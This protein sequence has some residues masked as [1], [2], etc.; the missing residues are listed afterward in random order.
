MRRSIDC[1][2]PAAT[3]NVLELV[4]AYEL[5]DDPEDS[6]STILILVENISDKLLK[7]VDIDTVRF[8]DRADSLLEEDW[9]PYVNGRLI[10][11][12]TSFSSTHIP[13]GDTG[14]FELIGPAD[15]GTTA[16]AQIDTI[17]YHEETN[18]P[19][20]SSWVKLVDYTWHSNNRLEITV[21]NHVSQWVLLDRRPDVV[22]FDQKGI[23][24]GLTTLDNADSDDYF[25]YSMSIAPCAT[26]TL[27]SDYVL[28]E[29]TASSMRVFFDYE[30]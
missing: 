4:G 23:P 25:R 16:R 10:T 28:F 18:L 3:G 7:F 30:P 6:R 27:P 14:Y 22:L 1:E 9:G 8:Y 13:P 5:R 11:E 15:Y 26:T 20:P 29:G 24:I 17:D 2:L 12:G 21:A 19:E